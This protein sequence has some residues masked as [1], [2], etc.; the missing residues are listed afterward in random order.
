MP[1]LTAARTGLTTATQTE[2]WH[3]LATGTATT[4]E[5]GFLLARRV[6]GGHLE[7]LEM[8]IHL[9]RMAGTAGM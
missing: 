6:R 4:H 8:R 2:P 7:T 9:L 3:I 1:I 5:I